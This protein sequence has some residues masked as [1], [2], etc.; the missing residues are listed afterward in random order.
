M[1]ADGVEL[2]VHVSVDGIPVVHHDPQVGHDMISQRTAAEIR[3]H[4]LPNG[5][6]IPTL[7]EA[8]AALGEQ[9]EVFVEVKDLPQQHDAALLAVLDRAPAPR[10]VR[11]HSFDHRLV[12]RLREQRPS[13]QYGVLS[14]SYPIDPLN[15]V[16]DARAHVLWQQASLV[17]QALTDRAHSQDVRVFAWTVD[18]PDRMR[19]LIS[20]GIDAIC[21]NRPDVAREV[22]G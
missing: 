21:S 8:F 22:C 14:T 11:V 5:E 2:D 17:D 1:G 16:R 20:L 7:T 15:Q 12:R 18:E 13:L 4:R 6:P 19:T 10:Q 9:L 3:K